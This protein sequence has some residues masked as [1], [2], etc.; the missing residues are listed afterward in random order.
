MNNLALFKEA[1]ALFFDVDGVLTNSELLITESGQLLRKMHTR[2]G[3][4]LKRA[5]EKGYHVCIITGGGSQGVV[6]RLKG[7]G[8]RHIY[9]KVSDKIEVFSEHIKQHRIDPAHILYMGDDIPDLEVMRRVGLPCCPKDAAPEIIEI[10]RYISPVIGGKGCVRDVLEKV[11]KLKGHW[12]DNP[13]DIEFE[14]TP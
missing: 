2:D 12:R 13:R 4:A 10:S 14:I 5:V 7:L 1:Q 9:T 8:I 3:F 6:E 11:L